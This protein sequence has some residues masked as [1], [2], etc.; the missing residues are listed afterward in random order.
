MVS[1]AVGLLARITAQLAE[2]GI[3]VNAVSAYY[4]DH[5]F[6][7]EDRAEEAVGLLKELQQ[8]ARARGA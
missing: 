3:S 7:P 6:I 8:A 2:H 5:L 1:D 4:H